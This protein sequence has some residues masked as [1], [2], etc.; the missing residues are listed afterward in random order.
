MKQKLLEVDIDSVL[1]LMFSIDDEIKK[2][3]ISVRAQIRE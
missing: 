1:R 2:G 3:N